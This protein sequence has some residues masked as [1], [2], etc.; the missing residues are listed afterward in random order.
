MRI[1]ADLKTEKMCKYVHF[2]LCV[3]VPSV[4]PQALHQ[5][6][7]CLR[8]LL[9]IPCLEHKTNDWVWSKVNFFLGPQEPLLATVKEMETWHGL[10]MSYATAASPKPSFRA[11]WRVGD[12]VVGR[13]NAGW[14]TSK[15][16]HPCPCQNCS[17]GPPAEKSGRGSLLNR[18][19]CP[20]STTK[21]VMTGR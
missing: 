20:P 14:T 17:Q 13:G 10:G 16:V 8:K 9:H 4:V 12:A 7:K 2:R 11:L 21:S 18:P 15:T 6:T 5:E 3:V 1:L 19:S